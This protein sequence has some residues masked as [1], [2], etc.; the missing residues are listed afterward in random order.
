VVASG[1]L[2]EIQAAPRSVTGALIDGRPRRI[3]SRLRPVRAEAKITVKG[4]CANNLKGIDVELPL[5]VL[6]AVTGVSGSGKSSL[7]KE[8]VYKGLRN[9]LL[10][11]TDPAGACSDIVGWQALRRVLEVD[12]SPIG[13]TPRS[14]P[15]SYVGFLDDIRRLFALTPAARARGYSPGR[16]SFNV[17][18]GRCEACQG[19]GRP[20]VEMSFLPDVYV[21]CESCE[22][23]RFNPETLEVL[24]KGKSIGDVLAM[25]FAEAVTFFD[26]VPLIRKPVQ[27]VCDVGLGYLTLG[28][29]SPT[30]SGGEAQRIKLA[31]QLARPADGQTL[32]I[33]DEPTTGLHPADIRRLIDVLHSLVDAGHTVAVIEHNLEI[34]KEADHIIDLG[35]EGGAEG[36][37]LVAAGSPK[38]ILKSVRTSHTARFLKRFLGLS[39]A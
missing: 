17:S 3:T 4:A 29:P 6:V 15:A 22:G 38:A 8:T 18:G 7:L 19:Q 16:F 26:A 9:R 36:G 1:S 39:A 27:F 11:R 5:G 24:Y 28:Q 25:S 37:R 13:R 32:Y 33:L 20:K 34:V 31:E 14:V 2:A 10:G 21:P 30:L 12:H 23:R 35:P